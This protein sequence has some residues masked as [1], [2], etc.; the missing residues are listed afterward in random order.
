M[1][2]ACE[3]RRQR[4][5]DG[6]LLWT[7]G[8]SRLSIAL[9]RFPIARRPRIASRIFLRR[10][11]RRTEAAAAY[12]RAIDLATNSPERAYLDRRL[13]EVDGDPLVCVRP[14]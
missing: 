1:L 8:R 11:D 4:I 5:V 12:R 10:L 9:F 6:W 7:D 13:A 3:S 14:S 2:G